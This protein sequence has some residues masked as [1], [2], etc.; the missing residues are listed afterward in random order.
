MDCENQIMRWSDDIMPMYEHG[1]LR[2]MKHTNEMHQESQESDTVRE[3]TKCAE[4]IL[5]AKH[6]RADVNKASAGCDHLTVESN[7][8]S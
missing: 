3:M 2:D 5:D 6:E 1:A 8:N 4:R 7:K